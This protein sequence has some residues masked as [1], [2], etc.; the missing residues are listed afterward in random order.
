MRQTGCKP[1]KVLRYVSPAPQFDRELE[2]DMC[3]LTLTK[4]LPIGV[5]APG[6]KKF[7]TESYED[8]LSHDVCPLFRPH[9]NLSDE[10]NSNVGSP[11]LKV[12]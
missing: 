1:G 5:S 11:R 2:K 7:R 3:E 9:R 12:A 10:V 4:W 8:R 6:S